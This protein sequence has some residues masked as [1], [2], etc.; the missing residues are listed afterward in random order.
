MQYSIPESHP[1][2]PG[3]THTVRSREFQTLGENVWLDGDI[4]D[5]FL[6]INC[7]IFHA[8]TVIPTQ[9]TDY[10][11]G[12]SSR[13]L[14]E[15]R[16][17]AMYNIDFD[18]VHSK[19]LMP[20]TTGH[21]WCLLII[22]IDRHTVQHVDPKH[23]ETSAK[24][25]MGR[26]KMAYNNFLKFINASRKFG[27]N[28]LNKIEWKFIPF[29]T[30]RPIQPPEDGNNCGPITLHYVECIAKNLQ[31][32][33]AFDPKKYREYVADTLIENSNP[34]SQ[35]CLFCD[36]D[37][38]NLDTATCILCKRFCHLYCLDNNNFYNHEGI[39]MLC[40]KYLERI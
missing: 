14:P 28:L 18:R 6:A 26:S 24:T 3:E 10:I 13:N 9:Q 7:D 38:V 17:W 23:L 30:K 31:F 35:I 16:N 2:L 21:H 1:C 5:A 12:R 22:D 8:A 36:R 34:M 39:C 32:N 37:N 27:E 4:I 11:L 19:I 33:L 25:I 15:N 40:M 20:Y 29:R